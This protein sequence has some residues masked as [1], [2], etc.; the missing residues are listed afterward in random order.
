MHLGSNE[1]SR[2]PD[3]IAPDGSEIRLL[4]TSSCRGSMVHCTLAP[5]RITK[6]V[7][8]RSVEEMW[9]CIAGT[10]ML[11]RS[12]EGQEDLLALAP[13][14]SCSIATGTCFQFRSDGDM[15]LEIVI[16]TMPPW[17][18][19]DEAEPCSGHWTPSQQASS[20]VPG[21]ASPVRLSHAPRTNSVAHFT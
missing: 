21:A 7:R 19:P 14:V 8:H 9:H 10:G 3:V 15:P 17:P 2:E 13:G 16:A 5:G 18:G 11:W 12:F 4:S 1:M 20:A 6:P